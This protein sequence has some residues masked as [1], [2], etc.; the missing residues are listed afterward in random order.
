MVNALEV[1]AGDGDMQ[2]CERVAHYAQGNAAMFGAKAMRA[3]AAEME[4]AAAAGD[5]AQVRG[6]VPCL[7]EACRAVRGGMDDYLR[8]PGRLGGGL[9]VGRG[10]GDA[11]ARTVFYLSRHAATVWNEQKRIQGQWDSELSPAGQAAAADLARRLAGLGFSRI[12]AA[13]WPLPGHGR[14]LEPAP[15]PAGDLDKRFA[16]AAFRAV[17][18]RYW[19]DGP[20]PTA[21]RRG[22]RPGVSPRPRANRAPRCACGPSTR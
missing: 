3:L 5:T 6:R 21:G 10:R 19:R 8:R 9:A 15:A 13:T 18:G 12:V 17:S 1:A 20:R 4:V 16:R 14:H 11:M 22:R 7:R 2:V